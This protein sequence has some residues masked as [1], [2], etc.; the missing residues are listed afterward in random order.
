VD[1]IASESVRLAG[2]GL[3]DGLEGCEAAKGVEALGEVGGGQG[4]AEVLSEPPVD[5]VMVA[6]HS[7]LL[8]SADC[9]SR[10]PSAQPAVISITIRCW[11][12]SSIGRGFHEK[13]GKIVGH[14]WVL[15]DDVSLVEPDSELARFSSILRFGAGGYF[16]HRCGQDRRPWHAKPRPISGWSS[17]KTTIFIINL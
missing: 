15:V 2:P 12:R 14:A 10:L 13:D 9:R 6:P 5:F 11:R 16:F 4:R 7:R 17:Q 8:E 3:A 1:R